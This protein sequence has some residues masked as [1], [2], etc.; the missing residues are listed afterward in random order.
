[1][2]VAPMFAFIHSSI[3]SLMKRL[4]RKGDRII[5]KVSGVL[6]SAEGIIPVD[7]S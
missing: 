3:K 6:L 7:E 1:M 2:K 5:S 4:K